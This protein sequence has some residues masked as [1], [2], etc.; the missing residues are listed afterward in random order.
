MPEGQVVTYIL[1]SGNH[2]F[3]NDDM[4]HSIIEGRVECKEPVWR[5]ISAS[6]SHL[7]PPALTAGELRDALGAPGPELGPAP[8]A[9]PDPVFCAGAPRSLGSRTTLR[10]G[11]SSPRSC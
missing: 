10:P 2:P 5:H 11:G 6:A 8:I 9:Q 4:Y 3:D 7:H 1:L